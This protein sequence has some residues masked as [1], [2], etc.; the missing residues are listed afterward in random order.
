MATLGLMGLIGKPSETFKKPTFGA[1]TAFATGVAPNT[2]LSLYTPGLP[3][4]QGVAEPAGFTPDPQPG[5]KT[6]QGIPVI[7]PLDVANRQKLLMA[8]QEIWKLNRQ[9]QVIE[10]RAAIIKILQGAKNFADKEQIMRSLY[11]HADLAAMA[12]QTKALERQAHLVDRSKAI[13][14]D[15]FKAEEEKPIVT[16]EFLQ[17]I[18]GTGAPVGYSSTLTDKSITADPATSKFT[19]S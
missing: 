7:A 13:L 12:Q 11:F 6:N 14:F 19:V 4:E 18:M 5:F 1:S 10:T 9:K 8:G 3:A 15:N 2:D 17:G 16:R